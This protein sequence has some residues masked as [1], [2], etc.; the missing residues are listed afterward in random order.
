MEIRIGIE[1]I[2]IITMPNSF[3]MAKIMLSIEMRIKHKIA[4]M[5][6]SN[7]VS[8]QSGSFL[9]N[10]WKLD[11]IRIGQAEFRQFE[12]K[13][14]LSQYWA[15]ENNGVLITTKIFSPKNLYPNFLKSVTKVF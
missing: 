8:F 4:I 10:V 7:N 11:S 12:L 3:K 14:F 5:G 13:T 15:T 2:A 6:N 9:G 1:I